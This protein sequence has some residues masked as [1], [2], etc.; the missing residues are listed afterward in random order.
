MT[1]GSCP[2][3]AHDPENLGCGG[4]RVLVSRKWTGKTLQRHRADRAEVVRQ[5]LGSAG[6][7]VP[8]AQR[9]A[10]DIRREDGQPRFMWRIWDPLNASV[11][12]Y[13]QVMTR[14]IAESMRWRAEYQAARS[15]SSGDLAQPP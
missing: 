14:A 3:K 15:L 1:P 12:V 9:L 8:D 11:P 5:V 6:I 7:D 13:R 2:G 4:R 10:A